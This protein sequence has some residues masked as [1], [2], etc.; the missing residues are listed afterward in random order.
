MYV[1]EEGRL[2]CDAYQHNDK[3]INWRFD[4]GDRTGPHRNTHFLYPDFEGFSHAMAI[5][6][7]H[8][9]VGGA[10][11]VKKLIDELVIQFQM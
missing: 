5:A 8:S 1:S 3:I 6:V 11:W 9:T 2:R 4:C 10:V 7:A